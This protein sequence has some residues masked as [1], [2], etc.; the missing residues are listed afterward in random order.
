M[1]KL[2]KQKI[3][4]SDYDSDSN[5]DENEDQLIDWE[6]DSNPVFDSEEA[7]DIQE[8]NQF[9]SFPEVNDD[10]L[11]VDSGPGFGLGPKKLPIRRLIKQENESDVAFDIPNVN[12]AGE[13]SAAVVEW[14]VSNNGFGDN[15]MFDCEDLNY[16]NM[17]FEP[18]TYF[19]FNELLASDENVRADQP[20]PPTVNP[21]Q[22]Q[23]GIT[24]DQQE[25]MFSVENELDMAP[26]NLCSLSDPMPDLFC[27]LC[28]LWIHQSCSPWEE[29]SS[30]EPETG[31]KCG[32]CRTW[33]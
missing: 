8:E 13:S 18:Q 1:A 29:D 2:Q 6:L 15:M 12:P 21:E 17:E 10:Q 19:S 9:Y 4:G 30:W 7:G 24:Y 5:S 25:P 33:S 16:D 20:D 3:Y 22:Y 32:Q 27:V 23:M 31:W 14:D 26:C 28:N 11:E